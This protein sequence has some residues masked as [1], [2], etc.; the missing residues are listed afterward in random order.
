[1]SPESFCLSPATL[2]GAEEAS[3]D[4]AQSVNSGI[5]LS[6]TTTPP[7]SLVDAWAALFLRPQGLHVVRAAEMGLQCA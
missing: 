5:D 1:M 6:A 7:A 2:E 3:F 4:G